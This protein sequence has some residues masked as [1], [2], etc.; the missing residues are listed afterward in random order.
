MNRATTTIYYI[1]EPIAVQLSKIVN[2]DLRLN[3]VDVG[4]DWFDVGLTLD[5]IV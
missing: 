4:L 5:W 1:L 3:W 2:C